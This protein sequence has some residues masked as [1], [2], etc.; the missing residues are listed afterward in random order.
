MAAKRAIV[1]NA[2]DNVAVTVENVEPGDQVSLETI[3]ETGFGLVGSIVWALLL[4]C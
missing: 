3:G 2:K 4:L 1:L